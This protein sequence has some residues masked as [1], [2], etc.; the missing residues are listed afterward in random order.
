MAKLG[1]ML[2]KEGLATADQLD[3]AAKIQRRDGCPLG[4][5]LVQQGVLTEDQLVNVLARQT[6]CAGPCHVA[7]PQSPLPRF[8]CRS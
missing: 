5:A 1:D 4:A 2:L 7:S 3:A 6:G 8:S